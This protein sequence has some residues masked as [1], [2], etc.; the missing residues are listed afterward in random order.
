[1]TKAEALKKAGID[2]ANKVERGA[3]LTIETV[4]GKGGLPEGCVV[5]VALTP[6]NVIEFIS[7]CRRWA[8][9]K[10]LATAILSSPH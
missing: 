3:G 7:M 8:E 1:M 10:R 9:S 5:A 2:A 4:K 6:A